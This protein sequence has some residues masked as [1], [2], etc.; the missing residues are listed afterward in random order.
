MVVLAYT[1][2][3]AGGKFDKKAGIRPTPPAALH[4]V[5]VAVTNARRCASTWRCGATA[6]SGASALPRAASGWANSTISAPRQTE[7]HAGARLAR[8]E[9]FRFAQGAAPRTGNACCSKA[10]L[11]PG[12]KVVLDIEQ[13]GGEVLTKSWA[14]PD[15]LA[16]Y[17]RELAG[18]QE[19]V[20][21]IYAA[22]KYATARTTTSPRAKGPPG[23]WAGSPTAWPS[24]IPT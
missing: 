11:L 13:T 4:G 16:G 7:R 5:G 21:P 1:R 20:C 24:G 3:H 12:V 22:E 6:G 9:I 23:R 19:A 17:L 2:L 18:D 10:V 15:G 14:Y 8:S